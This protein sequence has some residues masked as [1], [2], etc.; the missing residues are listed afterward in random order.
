M[1]ISAILLVLAFFA[2]AIDA[3]GVQTPRVKLLPLGLA[4]FVLAF[5]LQGVR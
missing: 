1:T 3:A 5:L 2:L 4:L